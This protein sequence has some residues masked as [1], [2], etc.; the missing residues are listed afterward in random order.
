MLITSFQD[1]I[2]KLCLITVQSISLGMV[3]S[4]PNLPYF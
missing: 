1:L 2:R 4:T 3:L